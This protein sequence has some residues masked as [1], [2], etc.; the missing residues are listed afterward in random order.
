[1]RILFT[2]QPGIGYLHPFVPLATA[3]AEA[4]HAVR[5]ATS[6][7]FCPTSFASTIGT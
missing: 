1:M 4:G 6:R 3:V 5:I 2:M 7:P